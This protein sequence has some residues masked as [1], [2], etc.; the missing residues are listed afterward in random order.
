M[1]YKILPFLLAI[2]TGA[3]LLTSCA[4]ARQ[5]ATPD[6]AVNRVHPNGEGNYYNPDALTTEAAVSEAESTAASTE[7]E[8]VQPT[9]Q[10]KNKQP[11]TTQPTTAPHTQPTTVPHTTNPNVPA[12]SI[13]GANI[14]PSIAAIQRQMLDQLLALRLKALTLSKTSLT[15]EAG[16][17]E[18]LDIRYDP[19]D[20][21][22]KLCT[23]SVSN[24]N[25]SASISGAKVT[26][27]GTAA[28]TATVTV[29]ARNGIKATCEVTVKAPAEA[30]TDDTVLPH[31]N[32]CTAQNVSRWCDE[33]TEYL[34]TEKGLIYDSEIEN[35]SLRLTFSTAPLG[36]DHSFN[37]A[38]IELKKQAEEML[39][40]EG[41]LSGAHFICTAE[42]KGSEYEFT[43]LIQIP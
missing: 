1:K 4:S 5:A 30:V 13:T 6:E 20:T 41:D 40:P 38:A 43:V 25:A 19:A 12:D 36:D 34:Q 10:K 35:E 15:L 32:L 37:T 8:T 22:D 27:T 2:I 24:G 26:V 7:A 28:G 23:V 14:N 16:K 18:T 21:I 42:E 29:T 31:G 39:D 33:L 3:A 9:T 17:S 11:A